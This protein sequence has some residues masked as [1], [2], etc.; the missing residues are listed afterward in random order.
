MKNQL[1][2][3]WSLGLA[4]AALPLAGGCDQETAESAPVPVSVASND[5][6][7]SSETAVD[8]A[9]ITNVP[10]PEMTEMQLETA[11]GR[12]VSVA[13]PSAATSHLSSPSTEIVKL[14]QAGLDEGVMLTYVTN[15]PHVFNLS[16]DDLVYL[17]DIGVPSSVVT[18]MIVHDQ[19]AKWRC[20]GSHRRFDADRLS[21]P[22]RPA[23][24]YADSLSGN[25]HGRRSR[26]GNGGLC[27]AGW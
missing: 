7:A 4:L 14:A 9:A 13:Q 19:S 27:R 23:A 17:N 8:T 25:R 5:S 21:E 1:F 12:I 24:R 10:A 16:S 2:R 22:T 20:A 6:V 11:P 15:S 18:A 3:T 26:G